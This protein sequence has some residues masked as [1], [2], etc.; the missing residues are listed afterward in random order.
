MTD[1]IVQWG[2]GSNG[3]GKGKGWSINI[4]TPNPGAQ[5]NISSD[6]GE[7]DIQFNSVAGYPGSLNIVGSASIQIVAGVN[8]G[9]LPLETIDISMTTGPVNGVVDVIGTVIVKGAGK[10]RCKSIRT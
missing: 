2:S 7:L 1:I 3:K 6:V 10:G 9:I 4:A 8:D 5:P